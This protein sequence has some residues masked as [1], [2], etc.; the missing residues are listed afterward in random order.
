MD[1]NAVTEI[2]ASTGR[3]VKVIVDDLHDSDA[4]AVVGGYVWIDSGIGAVAEINASTGA[5]VRVTR[6]A[7]SPTRA[8]FT[9][10]SIAVCGPDL[11]ITNFGARALDEFTVSTGALIR[12][13][14]GSTHGFS[15]P[16][17]IACEGT[18]LFVANL[19]LSSVTELDASTGTLIS[20]LASTSH[21]IDHP[22]A[23][24]VS[25]G[26]LLVLDI[27]NAVTELNASTGAFVR[28]IR[29]VFYGFCYP[30]AM[31]SDGKHMWVASGSEDGD[32]V[33]NPDAVTEID[34]STGAPMRIVEGAASRI[35]HPSAL[36]YDG[37]HI[38]VAN[39]QGDSVTELD[40][41]SG[42]VVRVVSGHTPCPHG[43]ICPGP[44]ALVTDGRDLWVANFSP[45]GAITEL[46]SSNGRVVGNIGTPD[47]T[48]S[49]MTYGGGHLWV[50]NL[51][52]SGSDGSIS[53]LNPATDRVV[54]V[55]QPGEVRSA[56]GV[57]EQEAYNFSDI[58]YN[59]GDLWVLSSIGDINNGA[60][61]EFNASSGAQVRNIDRAS[62][63]L[64]SS[65]AIATDGQHVWIAGSD[66]SGESITEIN[67]ANGAL[68]GV[69][70]AAYYEFGGTSTIVY[71]G[72]NM[73]VA[74]SDGN[75]VT[76]FPCGPSPATSRSPHTT[77]N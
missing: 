59:R 47:S 3:L 66:R 52:N 16:S 18:R 64:N 22:P 49:G 51:D 25:D 23:V 5:L 17:S 60:V 67:A 15:N 2:N 63:D 73:W 68:I 65:T 19:F 28:V 38:W 39:G 26:R 71:D 6:P 33:C 10:Q 11:W 36:A 30:G 14:Q 72:T 48:A 32:S 27:D 62:Y 42:A 46:D 24:A 50:V 58:V 76:V 1:A 44:S 53:E 45:Q 56:S 34:V 37:A 9:I 74:D 29:G 61:T 55:V 4:I 7:P 70:S 57:L 69:L 54:K 21:D 77:A 8:V 40:A 12:V 20:V 13:V 31:V 75:L 35:N 41:S 43:D